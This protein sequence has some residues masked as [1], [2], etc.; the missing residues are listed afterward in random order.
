M[1]NL[2]LSHEKIVVADGCGAGGSTF[3]AGSRRR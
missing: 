3:D 1:S 2:D